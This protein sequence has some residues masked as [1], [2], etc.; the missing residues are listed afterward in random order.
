MHSDLLSFASIA[1][2]YPALLLAVGIVV[3]LLAGVIFS[4]DRSTGISFLSILL[5]V[6]VTASGSPPKACCSMAA[7]SSTASP[8]T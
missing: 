3:L 1:P 7:S 2:A 6:A 8:A 4:K 5:L